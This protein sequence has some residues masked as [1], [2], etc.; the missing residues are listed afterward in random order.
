M[1]KVIQHPASQKDPLT[2]KLFGAEDLTDDPKRS[3]ILTSSP[4]A[5]RAGKALLPQFCWLGDD[6]E[7]NPDAD[8]SI[9]KNRSVYLWPTAGEEG[10]HLRQLIPHLLT[11]VGKLSQFRTDDCEDGWSPISFMDGAWDSDG[12][13]A[14]MK[15]RA[16]PLSRDVT[17]AKPRPPTQA[18]LLISWGS[19]GIPTPGGKPVTNMDTVVR[20]LESGN[21]PLGEVHLDTFLQ[22]IVI[23]G[24][25]MTD[26]HSRDLL[27]HCQRN[28]HLYKMGIEAIRDGISAYAGKRKQN[29]LVAWLNELPIWDGT[30]RLKD[31]F[32]QYYGAQPTSYASCAGINFFRSMIARALHPGCQ[33][34]HMV[35]LEG[36]QGIGKSTSLKAIC[37]PQWFAIAKES[38]LSKDFAISIQGK[39]VNEIDEMQSFTR[40]EVNAVKSIVSA[41]S[42]RFRP[43]WGR[44]AQDF[45]RQGIFVGT[46]NRADWNQDDTGA[47]R[48]W[49]IKCAF[50]ALPALKEAVPQLLAEALH[51]IRVTG[52]PYWLMP[53]EE[54][55]AEQRARFDYHPWQEVVADWVTGRKGV[56]ALEVLTMAIKMPLDRITKREQMV[57]ASI[58]RAMGWETKPKRQGSRVRN[59]WMPPEET[60]REPGIDDE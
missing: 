49:P 15:D 37:P 21:H 27:L 20:V 48:F 60:D 23:N 4:N 36:A 13:K 41:P 58:L 2:S 6:P 22:Q 55:L 39:W 16:V 26:D 42:D 43:V 35:I 44:C 40:S 10:D 56:T 59:V 47:R 34:D 30:R 57:I 33:Q 24:E 53:R 25:S 5:A 12:L 45:P 11:V 3:I 52:A 14:W 9:L 54:T 50:V 38:V 51:D 7:F 29:C 31:F 19:I 18:N 32:H 8:L 17:Q 1:A 28:L 46:T